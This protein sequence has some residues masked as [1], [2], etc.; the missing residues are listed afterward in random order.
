M[1][2]F[3]KRGENSWLLVVEAGYNAKGRRIRRTRTIRIEDKA[4]LKTKKKLNDYLELE[5]A[6][7]QMEVEAGEYI[8]PEKLLIKDFVKDWE[9]KYA[10][11]ALGE[12]TLETYLGHIKNHI[13]PHFGHMRVDQ[14]KPIHLVNWL[15]DIKR[16]DGKDEPLSEGT[17]Q[18]IYRVFNNIFERAED[19]QIIK[20]NPVAAVEEPKSE[21]KEA[22]VYDQEEVELLLEAVQSRSFHWRIFV[23][24]ALATGLRRRELL[25]LE[26]S[27]VDL[28]KGVITIN[29]TITR[30]KSGKPI[31]KKP[32]TKKTIRIISLPDSIVEELGAFQLH[33]K[34]EKMKMRDQWIEEKH[35]WLF[36]NEDGTHFYP[37]TPTTWWR[38]FINSSGIRFIRLHELRH[39]SATL[40]INQGVHAK[41]I[42]KRLGHSGIRITMDT[43]GHALQS[44]D[45]GAAE[46]LD[47]IFNRKE[48]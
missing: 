11:K 19:W 10:I 29:Q 4:L 2:S 34:K 26:W 33:W 13:L 1:A 28:E 14:L 16:L 43:Y 25:G 36:C 38:R 22:D 15:P 21:P 23:S 39:T 32:K 27:N 37:T 44:A 12:Q 31:I 3:Q 30:G 41:I 47:A 46:K 9:N 24:L 48:A 17:I 45:E 8:A 35:E 6:K 18:Y 42:S 20:E 5:L 7:F 40:L